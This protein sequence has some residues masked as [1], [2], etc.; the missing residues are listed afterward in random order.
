MINYQ[1]K[2][3]ILPKRDKEIG[4]LKGPVNQKKMEE[5]MQKILEVLEEL[6]RTSNMLQ[7][8]WQRGFRY[9]EE[10]VNEAGQKTREYLQHKTAALHKE[11]A[12]L[13]K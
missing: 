5:K 9:G 1:K 4:N 6:Q 13:L 11:L 2:T 12:E 10:P 7:T 8:L 3:P